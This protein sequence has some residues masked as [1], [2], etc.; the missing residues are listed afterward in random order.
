LTLSHWNAYSGRRT[1]DMATQIKPKKQKSKGKQHPV[2]AESFDKIAAALDASRTYP[3][4]QELA[5]IFRREAVRVRA[6][7]R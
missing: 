6:I 4:A 1:E 5:Q 7:L 3:S 2:H